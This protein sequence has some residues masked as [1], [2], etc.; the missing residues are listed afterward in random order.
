M[1]IWQAFSLVTIAALGM[2]S[3]CA[4]PEVPAP[5]STTVAI[6]AGDTINPYNEASNPVVMRLYQLSNRAAFEEADFWEVFYGGSENLA[7]VLLS[8]QSIGPIYPGENRVVPFDLLPETRY[9]GAF[10]EFADF[11]SQRYS[12][13]AAVDDTVLNQGVVVSIS[14]SGINIRG[15]GLT[16]SRQADERRSRPIAGFIGRL[17]GGT[18]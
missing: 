14:V 9:L 6:T 13:V 18:E 10:A 7:G 3:G 12:A 5:V 2:A 8:A 1:R 15:G 4:A 17:L 11:E 16:A